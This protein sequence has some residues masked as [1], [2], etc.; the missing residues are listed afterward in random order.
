M[1]KQDFQTLVLIVFALLFY[2][3]A[4]YSTVTNDFPAL[5]LSGMLCILFAGLSVYQVIKN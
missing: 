5:I 4:I 1:K 2:S 3:N